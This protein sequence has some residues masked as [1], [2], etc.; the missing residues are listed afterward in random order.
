MVPG[1]NVARLDVAEWGISARG[2]NN[3][4]ANKLLVMIDGRSI[5]TPTF[6]GTLWEGQ[7][8]LL[9]D[10]DRIEVIRGPGA[11]TWGANAVNG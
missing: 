11:A 1:L 9:E 5:Y 3:R 7:D 10:I 4:Y 6:S 2:F 8:V